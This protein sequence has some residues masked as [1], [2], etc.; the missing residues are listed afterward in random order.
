[1]KGS[2]MI[3]WI[4]GVILAIVMLVFLAV[5][6]LLEPWVLK[7]IRAAV[8]EQDQYEVLVSDV[9]ISI[10]K[11]SLAV[12]AISVRS[13]EPG[14]GGGDV[15]AEISSVELLGLNLRNAIFNN[16]FEINEVRITGLKGS[17][18]LPEDT[19]K[20]MLAPGHLH[21]HKFSFAVSDFEIIKPN[22]HQLYLIK[23]GSVTAFNLNISENDTLSPA[24]FNE[25]NFEAQEFSTVTADSLY[26]ISLNGIDYQSESGL[27][28]TDSMKIIPAYTGYK[29]TSRQR[30][31][32]DCIEAHFNNIAVSD[33]SAS[34][35]IKDK[36]IAASFVQLETMDI[37][38]FRDNRKEFNNLVKPI[39]QEMIYNYPG[40]FNIDS[41]RVVNGNV[42]YTEHAAEANLPGTITFN[43][44]NA[45]VYKISNN[46]AYK[47]EEAFL[48]V[49]GAANFMNK[50][51]LSVHLKAGLYDKH[52][53]FSLTGSMGAMNIPDINQ[54]LERIG[55]VTAISG[56][57][58][59][60]SF[61]F[62]ANNQK[63]RGKMVFRY[64][65][66]D[67]KAA[68]G[69]IDGF[70]SVVYKIVI[71][72]VGSRIVES[73]PL[74]GEQLRVG[75]IEFERDPKRSVFHYSV[76]SILSGIKSSIVRESKKKQ[77]KSKK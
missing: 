60:L 44:I 76:K 35:F 13:V 56:S 1:V 14:T 61:D 21:I 66:L 29:F 47:T 46:T 75:V 72:V 6:F 2:K 77:R 49:K 27:L 3:K 65:N 40:Y 17:L 22:S 51:A 48:E 41:V 53:T 7:K 9:A 63:S 4:A 69:S 71:F 25:L 20:P 67:L 16:N 68:E 45:A 19:V 32:K 57:S 74:P 37:V 28:R 64:R 62:V 36:N 73:N 43:N 24:I 39:F 70:T 33:F 42:S 8:A 59:N 54:P 5:V 38:V 26:T 58:Q 50:G 15:S 11:R 34:Q 18:V 55:Y 52:N 10:F 12:Q 31:Q 30:F 23:N